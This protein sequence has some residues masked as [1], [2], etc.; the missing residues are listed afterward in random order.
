MRYANVELDSK[1]DGYDEFKAVDVDS[2][3]VFVNDEKWEK[4][5]SFEGQ[6]ADAKVYVLNEKTGY[7]TFGNGTQGAIPANGQRVKVSYS[8]E[9][10]GFV[11]IADSMRDTMRQINEERAKNGKAAGEMHIYSSFDTN[12]FIKTMH[13]KGYDK[14]YD[15][16]TIHP[17]SFGPGN[18][19]NGE[20]FYLEAMKL[21]NNSVAHVRE[22]AELMKSYDERLVPVISEYGIYNSRNTLVRSQT[23][24][25]YIVRCIMEYA[26]LGS[27]YI[28]KHCLVDWYSSGGDS[29]GPTQQAVI[30][31][32]PVQGQ[33]DTGTGEGTFRFFKTPSASAFEMLNSTF[34]DN[35]VSTTNSFMPTLRNGVEQLHFAASTD[36]AGNTYVSIVNLNP[37]TATPAN[38]D[39]VR[40]KIDGVDLTGRS[41]EISTLAGEAFSS[42]NSVDNPNNVPI[43]KTTATGTAAAHVL[44]LDPHSF[45]IV[46]VL[47]EKQPEP[48][49]TEHTVTFDL[50]YEGSK[51]TQ[52]KVVDGQKVAEPETPT[53]EGYEFLG[54]LKG[55][56]PYN[57]D[58]PVTADL[59]LTASWKKIEA[60]VAKHTVAFMNGS[61]VFATAE[62]ENGSTVSKPQT[63][64][65]REGHTFEGWYLDGELYDFSTPV[66]DDLT[67]VAGFKKN[68]APE[69][70]PEPEP[71]PQP[72]PQQPARPGGL[73]TTGDMAAF[74][75][76]AATA[77]SALAYA[78]HK[79]KNRR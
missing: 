76:I 40:L 39:I 8:V 30:Q 3:E 29:L 59:T 4:V 72:Q 10:D 34:G 71:E 12:E 1:A 79:L 11:E 42:E 51:V 26:K 68:T 20:D 35:L 41:M 16:L 22:K 19:F 45:T 43:V 31:A 61:T 37:G 77:G 27:P 5:D 36:E 58:E 2:V 60:P 23:H 17:Y 6:G 55:T 64:P 24:A 62:V 18:N 49:P 14:K 57:F 74:A 67:L 33:S 50:N 44:E 73:P 48:E 54:W 69:P 32:Y 25:L 28:Q 21:G 65:V 15:G 47:A 46:K 70:E 13:N 38:K 53:R 63:N 78:G 7:F 56:E 52:V 9:R 66:T 75:A